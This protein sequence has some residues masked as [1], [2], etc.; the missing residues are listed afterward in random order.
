MLIITASRGS[1]LFKL[2]DDYAYRA[3]IRRLLALILVNRLGNGENLGDTFIGHAE[4]IRAGFGA[5]TAAD[6]SFFNHYFHILTSL[7]GCL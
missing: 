4:N 1:F 5:K 6:A 3:V 7:Y 2:T